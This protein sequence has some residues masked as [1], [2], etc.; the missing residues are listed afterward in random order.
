[1]FDG[2]GDINLSAENLGLVAIVETGSGTGYYWRR[3]A[4]GK[5]EIFSRFNL[6]LGGPLDVVFPIAF[7]APPLIFIQEN[8]GAKVNG[9]V[10][11]VR[12]LSK[13]GFSV[14]WNTW[15]PCG[16]GAAIDVCYH[17]LGN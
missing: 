2:T 1:M 17:A 4:D 15:S 7:T 14:A 13:A 5:I 16:S 9:W 11:R 8:G 3:F 10:L 12:G 6:T